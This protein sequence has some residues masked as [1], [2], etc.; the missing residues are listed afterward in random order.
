M[1]LKLV[2]LEL[3]ILVWVIIHCL[4]KDVQAIAKLSES[5]QILVTERMFRAH[6]GNWE[7]YEALTKGLRQ[8]VAEQKRTDE[9]L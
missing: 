8:E 2:K 7:G 5:G 9:F 1:Q 6:A 4:T 3:L